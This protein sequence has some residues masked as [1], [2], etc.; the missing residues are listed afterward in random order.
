M[1][2]GDVLGSHGVHA[3]QRQAQDRAR[4]RPSIKK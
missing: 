3:R 1:I 2:V 4:A